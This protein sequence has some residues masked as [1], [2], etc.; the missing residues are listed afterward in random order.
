MSDFEQEMNKMF[1]GS[2][3][4]YSIDDIEAAKKRQKKYG[5]TLYD[6]LSA[7]TQEKTGQ[8]PLGPIVDSAQS[9]LASASMN[10]QAAMADIN[11]IESSVKSNADEINKTLSELNKNIKSDFEFSS[12][13][14]ASKSV[15]P[16]LTQD[17]GLLEKYNGLSDKLKEKVFGQD[18]YIK[19]L[20]AI[21][22]PPWL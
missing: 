2:R 7:I 5:G 6:N 9:M 14:S 19:K 4:N 10:A 3:A 8:K 20:V 16:G 18:D 22:P 12:G 1:G 17:P 15:K 11:R 13:G 21:L